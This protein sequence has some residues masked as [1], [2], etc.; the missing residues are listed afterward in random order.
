MELVG[1]GMSQR[2]AD[3][4]FKQA[5]FE[6]RDG[7]DQVGVIELHDCFAAN[8]LLMYDALRL[9]AP[10]EAH[11]MVEAKDNSS[12]GKY[13]INPSGGLEAKGHP[14]G[15]TGIGMHFYITNQLRNW[16][17]PMQAPGLF[18]IP[19]KRGKLG[20]VHNIGLGGAVVVTLL[21]RPEFWKEGGK[22]GRD[23]VGYNHAYQA[24]KITQNDIDRVKSKQSS[25]IILAQ[26]KL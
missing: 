9:C 5:G 15:A 8:E 14:L 24:R 12:G 3:L 4:A 20:M 25:P 2:C 11:K 17:G 22:D 23:R 6:P 1:F 21:R 26:A 7:R 18:D 10:G 13:V 19:D 16:A